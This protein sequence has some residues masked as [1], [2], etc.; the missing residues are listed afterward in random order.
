[1][2]NVNTKIAAAATAAVMLLAGCGNDTNGFSAVYDGDGWNVKAD[3]GVLTLTI[4]D[5]GQGDWDVSKLSRGVSAETKTDDGSDQ[6]TYTFTV[7]KKGKGKI[8]LEREIIKDAAPYVQ[9]MTV[10][11]VADSERNFYDVDVTTDTANIIIRPTDSPDA[12]EGD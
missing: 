10:T 6:D 9:T 8:L 7:T 1:M 4:D 11:Y 5:D 3:A 12:E 2:M